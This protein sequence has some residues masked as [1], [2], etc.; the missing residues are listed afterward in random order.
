MA[1]TVRGSGASDPATN[2]A[3]LVLPP[4]A[5]VGLIGPA[6]SGKSTLAAA[7]AAPEAVLSSDVYRARIGS[8]EADQSVTGAAFA[9]LHRTLEQRLS[10]GQTTL[11]DATS[12]TPASRRA[13]LERANRAGAAAVALVM[14]LPPELVMARN[15]ARVAR[16]V[17]ASA[18]R[19]QLELL[20]TVTDALLFAEGFAMVRRLRSTVDVAG[21]D[22]VLGQA[23]A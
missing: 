16:V 7:L 1:G 5:L 13:L 12:L 11:V 8:G 9:A 14:D 4:G 19:R 20:R 22:L 10:A 2:A 6:G 18:L 3:I 23:P 17:P 15:A 21:L